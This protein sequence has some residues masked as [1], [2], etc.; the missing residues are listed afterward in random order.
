MKNR[1]KTKKKE[2]NINQ[3]SFFFDD[4]LETNQIQKKNVKSLISEDRVYLLFFFFFCLVTIFTLKI[5][6]VSLQ[7][8]KFLS[9]R[10]NNLN[11][12]PL[13]RDIVD[14]QGE[15][16]SRN[17][18]A[19]HAAIRPSLIKDKK[20][21][22][23]NIKIMF[24][25]ISQDKL[26]FNLSNKK[27]FY[28]KKGL[29]DSEKN[30]LWALGEKGIRFEPYQSRVYP[31]SNLYSHVI[32]QIN[33][34][35]YGISGVE[36][37]FDRELKDISKINNPLKLSLDTNLQYL[38]K[39]ELKKSLITF[40]AKSA[41][42]LLMDISNGEVLSLVSLPDYNINKRNNISDSKYINQITK[43]VFELGS[44]F[45]TFTIALALEEKIVDTDTLIN[46][47]ENKVKCSIHTIS[48]IHN[49]PRS[50]TV[51]QILVRSSNIG[52]LLIAKKVGK[53]K[54]INFLTKLNVLNTVSFELD[55]VGNPHTIRWQDKCKLETA[56]FGHGI[57]TT[58]LQAAAAYGSIANGGFI[59]NPTLKV[60]KKKF[61]K[62][63]IVSRETSSKINKILRKVVT[64]EEGTASFADILGYDVAGKTGTSQKYGTKNKNINTF[65]SVFPSSAPKYVLLVLI[66]EPK[67]ATNLIYDYRGV[68][69]KGTRNESGWNA[70]YIAGKII[71]QIG[72]ILAINNKEFYNN[73]VVKKTY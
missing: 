2:I 57:T 63:S 44:V 40:D 59:I 42:G 11:F 6:F 31:H 25:E 30:K 73:Y 7:E 41:A 67:V 34:D 70:V 58:P 38:I 13:R 43:G 62:E 26:K 54:F 21:F 14:R 52:T 37:F 46:N 35:N 28:L 36:G 9:V 24:P 22:L 49:F 47:I 12:T 45:K 55:E 66:D 39:K 18:N 29:T 71:K 68:K 64:D 16:I 23:I 56:A 50:L 60:E 69:I 20:K 3:K 61:S 15:L 32:G 5:I 1:K 4:F 10:E 19:F 53:E 48:D 8:P 72:P 17:I 33:Y 65:I 51:E 27:Y